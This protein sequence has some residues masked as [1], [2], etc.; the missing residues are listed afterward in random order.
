MI[1]MKQLMR[2]PTASV[3]ASSA[4]SSSPRGVRWMSA[5][6]SAD[7]VA[8]RKKAQERVVLL[9]CDHP[10]AYMR[11]HIDGALPFPLAM[12]SLKDSTP[13]HTGVILLEDFDH[14][15]QQL[16]LPKDAT[17]VLYDNEMS[18]KATR[19]WWVFRH[20]GFPKEQLKVLD[21]GWKEWI[22]SRGE[23]AS[24]QPEHLF[25]TADAFRPKA[26]K[27]SDVLV[28]LQTVQEALFDGETQFIDSRSLGEFTGANPNGNSRAGRVPGAHHFE[29]HSAV[30]GAAN[31]KFR[32]PEELEAQLVQAF[33][34]N[35]NH[36][37]ITY[38]QRGVRAAHTAFL[39]EEVL[40][41]DR[42]QIYED[43]MLEYLNH[44]DTDVEV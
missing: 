4:R 34:L 43:S 5:L 29:W 7:W 36:R 42:V 6:V 2:M 35:K 19:A 33:G 10:V 8:S 12:T 20:Y 22:A 44:H 28:G 41:F 26:P 24:G 40:G 17:L 14:A 13:R 37:A 39:L 1:A 15:M 30:D 3:A 21:G 27:E 38:C 11:A 31:D 18:L 32:S 9:D 16:Q 23:V 25:P